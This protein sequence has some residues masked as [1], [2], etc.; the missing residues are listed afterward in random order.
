ML[1]VRLFGTGDVS[2]EGHRLGGFP[3]QQSSLLLCYLLLNRKYPQ[4]RENLADLFWGEYPSNQARKHLR[5]ALWRLKSALQEIGVPVDQYLALQDDCVSFIRSSPYW[6]DVEIFEQTLSQYQ[7]FSGQDFTDDQVSL[8]EEVVA[9]HRGELL[10]GVYDDWCLYDREK[11]S[12]LHL[13]MLSKL[14]IFHGIHGNYD[15]GIEYGRRI[16]SIDETRERVHRQLM[17]LFWLAGDRNKA[18]QQ[19]RHCEAVLKETLGIL[20]MEE[21]QLLHV[22]IT[23]NKV[24]PTY[25]PAH[26]EQPTFE[27]L[28]DE[29]S[30]QPV[31]KH[32]LKRIK[33]LRNVIDETSDEL[34][35]IEHLISQA[36]SASDGHSRSQKGF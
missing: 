13:R 10:E 20:P 2:Y 32:A 11:F 17:W 27:A 22:Q 24:K 28:M 23:R 1:E 16:L 6:L 34:K 19:Y 4:H 18:L 29:G 5:N 31:A 35:Q 12:L 36:L 21:T 3:S 7:D 25:W 33:K 9:L 15:R 30:L 8:I 26:L 14:M